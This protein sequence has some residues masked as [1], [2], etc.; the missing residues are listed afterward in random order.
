MLEDARE[1]G[2]DARPPGKSVG[3]LQR[4]HQRILHYVFGEI[5]IAKLQDRHTQQISAMGMDQSGEFCGGGG[6]GHGLAL[7]I[8]SG[9]DRR[10]R[11]GRP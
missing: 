11:N 8:A 7:R 4:R 9:D 3:P 10:K 2:L 6:V 5:R 1:P